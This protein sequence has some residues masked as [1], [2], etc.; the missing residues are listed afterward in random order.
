M[1]TQCTNC[2][3]ILKVTQEQID[4]KQGRVRCGNCREVFNAID[5]LI[6]DDIP[7]LT[8]ESGTSDVNTP[9]SDKD[10]YTVPASNATSVPQNVLQILQHASI[11]ESQKQGGA[12]YAQP[13]SQLH[14]Q[15]HPQPQP[16]PQPHPHPQPQPQLH[17]Q[18]QPRVHEDHETR[19]LDD[20]IIRPHRVVPEDSHRYADDHFIRE[21][22]ADRP[23]I[24]RPIVLELDEDIEEVYDEDK[25]NYSNDYFES[26]SGR[27]LVKTLIGLALFLLLIFQILFFFR[28]AIVTALPAS[29]PV[30]Q[31]MCDVMGCKI[32]LFHDASKLS[33]NN[34]FMQLVSEDTANNLGTYELQAILVNESDYEQSW[35]YLFLEIEHK[36]DVVSYSKVLAPSDYLK[37]DEAKAFASK[38]EKHISFHFR[39]PLPV[40]SKFKLSIAN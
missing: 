2:H 29:R 16:Q 3:S 7:V 30:V 8:E 4:Q 10:I 18:S 12:T 27:S 36:P 21:T 40:I 28:N 34:K 22:R 39:A 19:G 20:F 11:V 35:P 33:I 38:S 15:P 24:E 31:K 9:T 14:P 25:E 37:P 17:P 5:N 23:A 6:E 13:Q 26:K 1:L 32:D